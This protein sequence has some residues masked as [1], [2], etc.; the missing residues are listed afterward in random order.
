MQFRNA[1]VLLLLLSLVAT[2]GCK[3]QQKCDEALATAR[4]AMQDEFL[5][6]DLARQWRQHAGKICGQ[7][8]ELEKLDKEILDREAAL[9]QAAADAAKKAADDGK[10]AIEK[11]TKLWKSFDKLD[12]K[13]QDKK[14]LGKIKKKTAKL[15]S[16][17]TPEYAKQVQDYNKKQY[18]SRLRKLEKDE[19]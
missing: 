11:A 1:S 18:K 15:V 10:K 2:A 16:G 14:A 8:P 5:D 19:K 17:L 6:M 3:N 4:K 7:G 13:E 12:E 9:T